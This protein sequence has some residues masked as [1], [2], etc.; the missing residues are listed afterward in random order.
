MFRTKID[1]KLKAFTLTE[2]M[3]TMVISSLVILLAYAALQ[4]MNNYFIRTGH[5]NE[6]YSERLGMR[7]VLSTDIDLCDSIMENE[8][9]IVIFS[10]GNEV[11]WYGDSTVIIRHKA[12]GDNDGQK[13]FGV[14]TNI[15]HAT[16]GKNEGLVSRV[17]LGLIDEAGDSIFFNFYKHYTLGVAVAR[18]TPHP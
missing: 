8:N 10:G 1:H 3:I 5:N 18:R 17:G 14:G 13:V 7:T 15:L 4:M 11:E 9:G 2:V 16:I 12:I 6:V